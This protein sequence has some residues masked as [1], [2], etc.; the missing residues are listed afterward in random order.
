MGLKSY[1]G[2]T[3]MKKSKKRKPLRDIATAG[4]TAIIGTAL[5]SET[6]SAV[7]RV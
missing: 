1:K 6:A 5:V 3:R 4:V 2:K 7:R